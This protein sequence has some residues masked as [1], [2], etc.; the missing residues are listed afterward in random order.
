V[1]V[2]R[3]EDSQDLGARDIF[4]GLAGL[5]RALIDELQSGFVM[6]AG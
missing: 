2:V 1:E 5:K 4:E 6:E 3:I